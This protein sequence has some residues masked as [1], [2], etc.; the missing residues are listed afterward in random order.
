MLDV[1]AE[2][3]G[4]QKRKHASADGCV[5]FVLS[6]RVAGKAPELKGRA[7]RPAAHARGDRDTR[8]VI[9]SGSDFVAHGSLIPRV[10]KK[11]HR[12]GN[13]LVRQHF[14]SPNQ[15]DVKTPLRGV[16]G[17]ESDVDRLS[18]EAAMRT[19]NALE[20]S[21]SPLVND[22]LLPIEP[23]FASE[24]IS[25]DQRVALEPPTDSRR[26]LPPIFVPRDSGDVTVGRLFHRAIFCARNGS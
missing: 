19:V 9:T 16:D 12:V 22:P 14:G 4:C 2:D 25:R 20:K 8:R 26:A 13:L 17:V 10:L 1:S 11:P 15:S 23:L 6:T 7:A 5:S 21:I 24:L 3:A 18:C